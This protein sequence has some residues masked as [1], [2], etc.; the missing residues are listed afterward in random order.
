MHG[1][2]RDLWL[3]WYENQR[4]WP[5]IWD[6]PPLYEPWGA[7]VGDNPWMWRARQRHEAVFGFDVVNA[8]KDYRYLDSRDTKKKRLPVDRMRRVSYKETLAALLAFPPWMHE[9]EVREHEEALKRGITEQEA[10]ARVRL[11]ERN[12]HERVEQWRMWQ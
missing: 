1:D 7:P 12:R 6:Q 3:A 9:P 10:E 5:P 8:L 4:Y 11:I 2:E